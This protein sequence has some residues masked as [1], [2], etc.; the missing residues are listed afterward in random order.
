MSDVIEVGR[1]ESDITIDIIDYKVDKDNHTELVSVAIAKY[2]AVFGDKCVGKVDLIRDYNLNGKI[3]HSIP[4][5]AGFSFPPEFIKL[6]KLI[7][8][9]GS[10]L[11]VGY[12]SMS[13]LEKPVE[14]FLIKELR[15]IKIN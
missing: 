8:R 13:T 4:R 6:I 10:K 3:K 2:D 14:A 9:R 12:R 5:V 11:L 1:V 7:K 15:A